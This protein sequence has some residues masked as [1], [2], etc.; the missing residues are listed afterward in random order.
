VAGG[1]IL[2]R[3]GEIAPD[4]R[5]DFIFTMICGRVKLLKSRIAELFGSH[6]DA[7]IGQWNVL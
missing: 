5:G 6:F 1:G 7:L 3:K 2:A 4:D